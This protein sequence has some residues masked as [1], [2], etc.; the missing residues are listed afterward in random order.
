M[1]APTWLKPA[2]LGGIAGGIA[3]MIVGFNLVGWKTEDAAEQQAFQKSRLAVVEALVPICLSQQKRDPDATAKLA[4]LAEMR[5]SY[6]QRDFVISSGWAT[7][8]EGNEP[9][10]DV[11]TLCAETLAKPQG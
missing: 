4:Q 3:T 5:T 10:R 8:P 9:N 1:G 6:E 7:M 11:A 2:I